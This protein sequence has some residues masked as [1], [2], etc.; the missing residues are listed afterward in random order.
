MIHTFRYLAGTHFVSTTSSSGV[1]TRHHN[2]TTR[3]RHNLTQ[4]SVNMMSSTLGLTEGQRR[5]I[6]AHLYVRRCGL[7]DD[8]LSFEPQHTIYPTSTY[9][10]L[11]YRKRDVTVYLVRRRRPPCH[12][13]IYVPQTG[14]QQRWKRFTPRKSADQ[15]R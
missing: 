3:S 9:T 7:I 5:D 8:C 1:H 15:P 13:A 11:R 4:A 10:S 14:P 6:R 2:K 12:I